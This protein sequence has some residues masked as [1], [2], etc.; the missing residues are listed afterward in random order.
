M[1]YKVLFIFCI[2]FLKVYKYHKYRAIRYYLFE[3]IF[4]IKIINRIVLNIM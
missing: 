1:Q 4:Q 3:V 2:I